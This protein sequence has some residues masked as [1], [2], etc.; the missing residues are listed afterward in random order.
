M[1]GLRLKNDEKLDR[2]DLFAGLRLVFW[3][4]RAGAVLFFVVLAAIVLILHTNL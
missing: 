4:T 3:L 2:C 1:S